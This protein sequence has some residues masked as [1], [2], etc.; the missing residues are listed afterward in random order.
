MKKSSVLRTRNPNSPISLVIHNSNV[1]IYGLSN[2]EI[3][4]I[5]YNYIK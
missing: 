5:K 1:T 3:K 2:I 4:Q